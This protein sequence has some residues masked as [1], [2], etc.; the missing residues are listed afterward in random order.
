[1]ASQPCVEMSAILERLD[2]SQYLE[3]MVQYGF[4]SWRLLL[5]IREEDFDILK[6][7]LGHRRK[8]QLEIA[9]FQDYPPLRPLSSNNASR[10]SPSKLPCEPRGRKCRERKKSNKQ[11]KL[12]P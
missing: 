12:H 11:H 6:L 10:K 3:N 8:L 1:M 5:N 9:S 2:I 7:K 4:E